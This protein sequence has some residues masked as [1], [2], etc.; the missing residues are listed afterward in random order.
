MRSLPWT[1]SRP[2][3]AVVVAAAL[4]GVETRG[5][6]GPAARPELVPDRIGCPEGT[7]LD[8]RR[9]QRVR[10]RLTAH[11]AGARLLAAAG[12]VPTLCYGDVREGVLRTDGILVLQRDRPLAANA[13][14]LGHL[15]HHLVYGLPVDENHLRT[16]E[17]GCSELAN[18]ADVEEHATHKL[19]NDLRRSFGL[20]P[21]AFEDVADAYRQRCEGLRRERTSRASM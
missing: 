20:P 5:D 18:R 13:A 11:Q 3:V 9:T 19:E 10:R 4:Y 21:L 16:S 12:R 14:R 8:R 2:L 1:L 6:A 15:L 7:A 17:L